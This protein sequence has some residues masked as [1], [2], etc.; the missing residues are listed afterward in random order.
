MLAETNTAGIAI[1]ALGAILLIASAILLA[2]RNRARGKGPEVPYTMRPGPSDAALE[3][4]LLHRYQGW[5]VVLL[6]FF[7]AWFPAQWL[8]EPDR[9]VAQEEEL[10]SLAL[11]RGA[12]AV[13]PFSEE[14]QLGVG[15]VNCHGSELQGGVIQFGNGYASP[16]N[17]QNICAG[18]LGNPAHAAIA[19][20]ED[21]Y[22]VI[23]EGRPASGMPTWS[24]RN[25]GALTDQQINDIVI[26][27]VDMS[28]KNIPF[29][30]NVCINEEAAERAAELAKQQGV[31]LERP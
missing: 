7:V 26:Y 30:D 19:S 10:K 2:A 29:E 1:L 3:T 8:L 9:N 15:C 14:N 28:S 23:A 27:L 31:V 25:D 13:L 17:L 6:V 18:N 16:P 24:I 4:P 12:K 22:Q 21:I 20:I 5:G 11:A